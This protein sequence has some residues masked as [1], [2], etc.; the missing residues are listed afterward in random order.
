MNSDNGLLRDSVDTSSTYTLGL[1]NEQEELY[2]ANNTGKID[3]D[4]CQRIR[5]YVGSS[6]YRMVKFTSEQGKDF[7]EPDFVGGTNKEGS[8]NE[9][10]VQCINICLYLMRKI[11][12]NIGFVFFMLLIHCISHATIYSSYSTKSEEFY[13]ERKSNVLEKV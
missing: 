12:R 10:T 5:K 7:D 13:I 8:R 3:T 2:R 11:G 9:S 4:V 1:L 6:T